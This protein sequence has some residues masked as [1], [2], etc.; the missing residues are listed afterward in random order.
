[1]V[2]IPPASRDSVPEDQREAFDQFVQEHGGIP[3]TGP[4]STM[5]HAPEMLARGE[6]LRAYLRGDESSL[7]P[8]I[9]ELAM[10][11]TAREMD[12]Q[13][14]WNAHVVQ[15][16]S[17]GLNDGLLDNLRD[18]QPLTGLSPE[19]SAVVD[20]G[21]ELFRTHRVAQ[22]VFD[23]ALARFGPRG[24]TELT[25]LMGYYAMLAFNV[26]AFEVGM[27]EDLTEALLPI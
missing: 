1:M 13:F 3:S 18:K 7:P 26:N 2:R 15:G 5:I 6:H 24:L 4:L 22:S 21:R 11:V 12:C 25:S 8:N 10:L 20:Y 23:A 14:I 27:P 9:R 16:R 17:W 19:E